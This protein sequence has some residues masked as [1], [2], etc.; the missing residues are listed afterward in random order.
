VGNDDDTITL[1]V[2]LHTAVDVMMPMMIVVVDEHGAL[3]GCVG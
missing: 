3:T 2:T 1:V